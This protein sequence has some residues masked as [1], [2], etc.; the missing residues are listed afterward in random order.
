MISGFQQWSC[1][2][3][4]DGSAEEVAKEQE[5][6]RRS[7]ERERERE[8][9]SREENASVCARESARDTEMFHQVRD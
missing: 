8:R 6:T 7:R 3:C 4:T 9:E 1:S 2:H 5:R